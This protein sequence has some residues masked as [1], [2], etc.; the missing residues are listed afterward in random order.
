MV[1]SSDTDTKEIKSYGSLFGPGPE[2][3]SSPEFEAL[4]DKFSE[5]MGELLVETGLSG[6]EMYAGYKTALMGLKMAAKPNPANQLIGTFVFSFGVTTMTMEAANAALNLS[7][8]DSLNEDDRL[9]V[10]ASNIFVGLFL[11]AF[12]ATHAETV[13]SVKTFERG[14][15]YLG[16][17]V[18][19]FKK[20]DIDV[21]TDALKGGLALTENLRNQ[22]Y[23]KVRPGRRILNSSGRYEGLHSSKSRGAIRRSKREGDLIN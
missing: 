4:L 6:V 21:A 19:P 12:S 16:L 8:D 15:N 14:K 10:N 20:F 1:Q 2:F 22:G 9:F 5:K 13:Q 7:A 3:E 11:S 17:A 23:G 18:A